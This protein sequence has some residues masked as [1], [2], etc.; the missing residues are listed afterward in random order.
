LVAGYPVTLLSPAAVVQRPALWLQTITRVGATLSGAPNFGFD[1]CVEKIGKDQLDG[2]ALE[3]WNAAFSGAE[4]VRPETLERFAAKFAPC[5]FDPRALMPCYGLAEATLIVS[6]GPK[7]RRPRVARVR[8]ADFERDGRVVFA[9]AAEAAACRIA[10]SGRPVV[11]QTVVIVDPHTLKRCG[12]G[13]VGE[14]WVQGPSV[15][16]GYWCQPEETDRTFGARLDDSAGTFLRTGDLGFLQ[17]GDLFIAGRIKD[18][19]IVHGVNHYPQDVELTVERSHSALRPAGA[20]AFAVDQGGEERLVVAQELRRT[21]H[22]DEAPVLETMLRAIV[23]QHGIAPYAIALLRQGT[24]PKTTSGKVQR[25]RTRALFLDGKLEPVAEW[26]SQLAAPEHRDVATYA[27]PRTPVEEILA[28][29]W[30]DVLQVDRVGIDD[31]FFELGGTSHLLLQS[32]RRLEAV[33]NQTVALMAL[34]Q[35]PTIRALAAFLTGAGGGLSAVEISRDR[36]RRRRMSYE[37]AQQVSD[38]TS[39]RRSDG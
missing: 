33:M 39:D 11:G 3:T 24:L 29:A 16:A 13:E 6:G 5:G 27:P 28:A 20:A 38:A 17:S 34:F 32:H 8:R 2:I 37:W 12:E 7:G 26:H 9:D 18:V 14:V 35:Y 4:A 19:I 1:L 25:G 15:S 31:N 22:G 30:S 10:A 36:G 21:F 23:E